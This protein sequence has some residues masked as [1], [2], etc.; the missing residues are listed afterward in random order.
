MKTEG[1]SYTEDEKFIEPGT[2]YPR[3]VTGE[4]VEKINFQK[5][6]TESIGFGIVVVDKDAR[7]ISATSQAL[8]D[9]S[10]IS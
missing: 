7:V 6:V 3:Q 5:A 10:E 9:I 1:L 4:L 2:I 8:E